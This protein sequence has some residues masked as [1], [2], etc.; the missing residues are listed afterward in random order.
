MHPPQAF[1]WEIVTYRM[2]L[3][4]CFQVLTYYTLWFSL[5]ECRFSQ[6]DERFFSM[7][8]GAL[9]FT[10][11]VS[12]CFDGGC[13]NW[14]IVCKNLLIS[15]Y[16]YYTSS[17]WIPKPQSSICF[18]I[19]LYVNN[20]GLHSNCYSFPRILNGINSFMMEVPVYRD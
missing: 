3:G 9:N 1:S 12:E 11:E 20:K 2:P 5:S 18:L 17:N 16:S 10:E 6:N 8:A 7:M 15:R 14:V 4:H 19:S 13:R